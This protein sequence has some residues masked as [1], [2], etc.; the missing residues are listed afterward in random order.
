MILQK[1]QYSC[2]FTFSPGGVHKRLFK[3]SERQLKKFD[4]LINDAKR[5]IKQGDNE[6]KNCYSKLAC[7]IKEQPYSQIAS[8]SC[9]P[10]SLYK[11][12]T[13]VAYNGGSRG[14]LRMVEYFQSEKKMKADKLE[15][16]YLEFLIA[17]WKNVRENIKQESQKHMS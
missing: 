5:R 6:I 2:E 9:M 10:A 11:E 7:K 14:A 12:L 17:A 13:G 16:Q 3:F 1:G 4:A 15:V 8:Y